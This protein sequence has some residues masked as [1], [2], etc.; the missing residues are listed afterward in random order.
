MSDSV[1]VIGL[2]VVVAIVMLIVGFIGN[3]IVDGASNAMRSKKVQQQ[4]NNPQYN[5][6]ESLAARYNRVQQNQTQ[7]QQQISVPQAKFCTKCVQPLN[8]DAVFCNACG[9]K[10]ED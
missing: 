6:T 4:K 7:M 8:E 1:M 10:V 9:N 3:K 2:I 5:K